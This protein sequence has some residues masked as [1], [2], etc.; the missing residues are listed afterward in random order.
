MEMK[1]KKK[2]NGMIRK[3]MPGMKCLPVGL[4]FEAQG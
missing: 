2:N 4:N 3:L 1:E